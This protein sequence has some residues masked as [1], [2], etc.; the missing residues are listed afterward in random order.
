MRIRNGYVS[1]SSSSSF[2]VPG[3]KAKD[4]KIPMYRLPDDMWRA[5]DRN[6]VTWDGKPLNLAEKS[7]EWWLTELYSDCNDLYGELADAGVGY[8][9]GHME[10]YGY[11]AGDCEYFV[12][13]DGDCEYF[14]P[15]GDLTGISGPV[16]LARLVKAVRE[17]LDGKMKM[18]DKLRAIRDIISPYEVSEAE[19]CEAQDG[20]P[21]GEPAGE[22][23]K[24][25]G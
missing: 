19:G 23:E 25:D 6:H 1:N 16:P 7:S 18:S 14:V 20:E 15:M 17:V 4:F 21:A 12:V 13:H 11:E 10:P 22:P 9:D 24:A 3:E 8:L 2:L 5:I